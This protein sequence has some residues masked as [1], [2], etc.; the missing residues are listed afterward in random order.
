MKEW[1]EFDWTDIVPDVIPEIPGSV[2]QIAYSG[3]F[4]R[5]MSLFRACAAVNEM[6]PRVL[7]LTRAIIELNPAHYSIWDYR[8]EVVSE[9]GNSVFD[10][11][12]VGLTPKSQNHPPIGEDGDWLNQ[13]TLSH[14]KNYQVW[15][16]RQHLIDPH[17]PLW[18]RGEK[19]LAMLVFE[20]DPKNFHAWSHLKWVV[21]KDK[22]YG[23][24]S[25]EDGSSLLEDCARMIAADVWNNSVWSFRYFVFAQYPDLLIPNKELAFI[26]QSLL[27]A[28]SNESAWAYLRGLVAHL[29]PDSKEGAK[30]IALEFI[31]EPRAV[32]LLAELSDKPH[33]EAHWRKL[34]ELEPMRRPFWEARMSTSSTV[35]CD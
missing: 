31:S 17:N 6:S 7:A 1:E 5:A 32:E 29:A 14:A 27:V 10:Y 15:N 18:F 20:D 30:Y 3:E 35:E 16:Y 34:C 22:Q 25:F 9:L 26:K 2:A 11:T 28:P 24:H 12:K 13:F 8:L 23:T 33:S 19:L 21:N 4:S